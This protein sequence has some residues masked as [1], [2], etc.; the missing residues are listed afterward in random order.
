MAK[1]K[2]RGTITK[3]KI[4]III[5]RRRKINRGGNGRDVVVD[6]GN[7]DRNV[8]PGQLVIHSGQ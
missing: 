8:V 3:I 1:E 7:R 2:T 5:L 6:I 4:I